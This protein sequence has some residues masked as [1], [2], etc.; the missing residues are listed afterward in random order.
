[1]DSYLEQL[2]SQQ[3][4][5][6]IYTGGPELVIAGAGS[7]KTRVLTYKI[8][9]LIKQGYQPWRMMALTF[10]NKAAR[11]MKERIVP[12]VGQEVA[13][14]LWM[15]T[16]HSIFYRILRTNADRI[17]FKHDFTIYDASDSLS[18]IKQIVKDRQLD[19][20]LYKPS[21]LQS[22]ISNM[23]NAMISPEDYSQNKD[24]MEEDTHY[25]RPLTANVYKTYWNRCRIAGA[26]DFD[27][28]L[29]YTNL[30]LRDNPDVLQ[31]Y[32]DYFQYI[33]IDEYQDTNF[34][35][36]LIIKQLSEKKQ[37]FCIVGDD[38]QSIY[39][40]RGANISNI[41][42]LQNQ[43]PELKTF[44]LEQNYRSSQNIIAAAN[45]LIEKNKKQIKKHIFSENEPGK[46]VQVIRC[47]S[48]YEESYIIANTIASLKRQ[49][50][51]SWDDF[52]VLYRTNSQSRIIEK[53]LSSGGLKDDHGN[54]RLGIPYRI[55]GG[56][57]FYQ[58]KEVKDA[59]CYFRMTQNPDDDEALRRIINYPSRG[60]GATTVGKIQKCAIDHDVSMWQVI[61]AP[62]QYSLDVNKGTLKKLE[63]FKDMMKSFIQLNETDINAHE[64][65]KEIV[66]KSRLLSDLMSDN[67]P[68][69]ISRQE[70]LNELLNSTQE[71]VE[72]KREESGEQ[73]IKL[74]DYMKEVSL[75]TDQDTDE[76]HGPCVTLMTVHAAKGLEFKN[77]LIS[78]VEEGR[79]PSHKS[80][81]SLAEI[82]EERRLL[83]VAI[84][85]AKT[86][87]IILH[88]DA[89]MMNGQSN[90]VYP[91]RF[92]RDIDPKYLK[93]EHTSLAVTSNQMDFN[94]E[95][96]NWSSR[97]YNYQK[98]SKDSPTMPLGSHFSPVAS[99]QNKKPD[100]SAGS[101]NFTM[102]Q[103]EEI[104]E[105]L[106]ISHN[107]FGQG[108]VIS[109]DTASDPKIMVKFNLVGIKTLLLKFAKF[110][111]IK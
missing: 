57:A 88:A 45:S 90:F 16:F 12:L 7:G 23:K 27:D 29:F 100:P 56:L 54:T 71:F 76:K 22:R 25:N 52:A 106:R 110:E 30:L 104:K 48:E 91:S 108:T 10:T 68:E 81:N 92:L 94:S 84:T 87:C 77:I 96:N 2:N 63:G 85:R 37:M 9:H 74:A 97:Q 35:Q 102:H 15:G 55:Y 14:K 50:G 38:A 79:F 46:K 39:S 41:L 59:I 51:S 28:L 40:F 31:R 20:Q 44:K 18:L 78:G 34:A 69:N 111:I 47:L 6:V 98:K 21:M 101:G 83:Y 11:E 73:E 26:M 67:T 65:A 3:R 75:A 8:V 1:M 86:T 95:R 53:A 66:D 72:S 60:I 105:G 24:L 103:V 19:D 82:E 80:Q 64:L 33:L 4:D 49:Q 58:R 61:N 43:Y 89:I 13:G 99:V 42:G 17:G 5:A 109:I 36:Y 93:M 32:Q 70:N 107:R 62:R